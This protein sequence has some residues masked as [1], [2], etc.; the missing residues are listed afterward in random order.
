M[1]NTFGIWLRREIENRKMT[2]S[3]FAIHAQISR[4]SIRRWLNGDRPRGDNIARLAD[5]LGLP[6]EVIDA[7]LGN[8]VAA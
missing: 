1:R 3:A 4:D 7:K 8:L 5:A 6:R 2:I